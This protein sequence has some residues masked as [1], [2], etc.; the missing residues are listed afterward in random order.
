MS[1]SPTEQDRVACLPV[2]LGL[3]G[4]RLRFFFFKPKRGRVGLFEVLLWNRRPSSAPVLLSSGSGIVT[5][6]APS[7]EVPH[8][9]RQYASKQGGSTRLSVPVPRLCRGFR[10][11]CVCGCVWVCVLKCC[12]AACGCVWVRV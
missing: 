7:G 3:G 12:V 4:C 6:A 2:R 10:F 5:V 9:C 1:R 11:Y 8:D